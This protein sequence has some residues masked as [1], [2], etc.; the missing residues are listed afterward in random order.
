MVIFKPMQLLRV[1]IPHGEIHA[2]TQSWGV[3]GYTLAQPFW[4]KFD[5]LHYESYIYIIFHP[6]FLF[7]GAYLSRLPL[8]PADLL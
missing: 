7:L 4:G 5:T 2:L 8:S 3:C 1:G 6:V